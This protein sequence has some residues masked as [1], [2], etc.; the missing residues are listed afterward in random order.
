MEIYGVKI[1]D[2][3][4]LWAALAFVVGRFLT[5]KILQFREAKTRNNVQSL[6]EKSEQGSPYDDIEPLSDKD[7]SNIEPIKIRPF[8]PKFFL[9]MGTYIRLHSQLRSFFNRLTSYQI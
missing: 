3:T 9:T 4:L 6:E 5:N 8:K 7:L 2:F 1:P